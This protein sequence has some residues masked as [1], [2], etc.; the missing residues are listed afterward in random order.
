V[1]LELGHVAELLAR[2]AGREHDADR[3]RQEATGDEGERERRGL[4]QPLRVIDDTQQRALLGHLREQAQHRQSH[5]EAIRDGTGAE[6]EHDLERSSLRRREP[7]EPVEERCAQLMQA[8][9]DSSISESTPAARTT[10][11]SDADAV[12]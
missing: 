5:D 3:L 10:V 8:G 7:V 9:V 11:R 12:K 6:P 4:I 2:L 1:D